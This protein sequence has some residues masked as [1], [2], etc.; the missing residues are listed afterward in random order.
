MPIN[1]N[2]K[3]KIK[4]NGK[5]YSSPE[6]M[7]PDIRSLYEKAI[8]NRGGSSANIQSTTNSKIVFNGQTFNNRDEMP[9]DVRK[10]YDSVM[11]SLDKN[12]DGIP[13]S[14][15]ANGGT[16]FQPS[17]PLLPTQNQVTASSKVTSRYIILIVTMFIALLFIGMILVEVLIKR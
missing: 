14:L 5:E 17:V 15:Q 12:G 2:V 9:A 8:A 16:T 13:D 3:T 1:F 11:T 7:P 4:I 10:I 6:E